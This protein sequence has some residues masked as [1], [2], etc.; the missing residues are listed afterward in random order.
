MPNLKSQY[1]LRAPLDKKHIIR[2]INGL[3]NDVRFK[4]RENALNAISNIVTAIHNGYH[5]DDREVPLLD[6]II[7]TLKIRPV[8]HYDMEI[9]KSALAK[10]PLIMQLLILMQDIVVKHQKQ[11]LQQKL[12][13]HCCAAV[14]LMPN[15]LAYS[16]NV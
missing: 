9:S 14:S 8:A 13:S 16:D 15:A 7:Q 5:S 1:D 12:A 2:I 4:N 10:K 11:C 3:K 6:I